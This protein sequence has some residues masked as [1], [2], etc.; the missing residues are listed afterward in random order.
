MA[1]Y[2]KFIPAAAAAVVGVANYV[3][4]VLPEKYKPLAS[5]IVMVVGAL[6]VLLAPKNAESAPKVVSKT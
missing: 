4:P 2:S 6:G 1:Q 5:A 3:L